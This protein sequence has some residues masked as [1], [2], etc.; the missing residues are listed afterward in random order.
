MRLQYKWTPDFTF[1]VN[2]NDVEDVVVSTNDF[3]D[4]PDVIGQSLKDNNWSDFVETIIE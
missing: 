1:K 4:V 2:P 3:I